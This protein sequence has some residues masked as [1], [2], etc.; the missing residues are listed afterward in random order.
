MGGE[1]LV[2][3]VSPGASRT[4]VAGRMADGRLKVRV[5]APAEA[6]RANAALVRLLARELGVD[7]RA[8]TLVAGHGARD[9]I[10]EVAAPA[11]RV[12]AL[13]TRK[14]AGG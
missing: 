7:V 9:K 4:E 1:R 12:R 8:V 5:A 6:G 13:G 10:V 11:E 3:R 14:E 2:V